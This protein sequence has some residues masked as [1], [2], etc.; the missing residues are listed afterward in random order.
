M[1]VE[2][3]EAEGL[4]IE[5][6]ELNVTL[7]E[8]GIG[9]VMMQPYVEPNLSNTGL[10]QWQDKE[11]SRQIDRITRTLNIADRADHACG[12]THFTIFPEYSIPGLEGIRRIEEKL[13]DGSWKNETIVLGG[14]D[15]LTKDDYSELCDG[16]TKD[17]HT[18]NNA[19]EVGDDEWIN[20]A[21]LWVKQQDGSLGRW[22]QP[23]MTPAL[24]ERNISYGN[25]FCGDSV[26]VFRCRFKNG[27]EC[28]FMVLICFDFMGRI[29]SN[30]GIRA[31]LSAV[32]KHWDDSS[33]KSIDLIFLLEHNEKP[34]N[35]NFL[36]NA[37][38]Y[39][40]ETNP[41]PSI[42]R[43]NSALFF[44]NTA[45]G[46][47]PGK[48]QTYGHSSLVF[49]PKVD[50][51]SVACPPSFSVR[52][53]K[54]RGTDCLGR[55][56][57][58]LFR[59][60]GACVHSF[61]FRSPSFIDPD[62]SDRCLPIDKANVHAIEADHEAIQSDQTESAN[63][64]SMQGVESSCTIEKA[65]IVEHADIDPRISGR[66]VPASVKWINDQLDA[67]VPLFQLEGEQPL[68]E[69]IAGAHEKVGERIRRQRGDLLCRYVEMT[70]PE[71]K[72][73]DKW[74]EIGQQKHH[75]VDN[76]GQEEA[77]NL[78]NVLHSLSVIEACK[79]LEVDGSP[80]HATIKLNNESD[81]FDIIVVTG[82]TNEDCI[83]YAIEKYEEY[84]GSAQRSVIVIIR[85]QYDFPINKKIFA[86]EKKI[87]NNGPSITSP[88]HRFIY[89]KYQD[90]IRSCFIE[91]ALF[92]MGLELQEDLENKNLSK[93]LQQQFTNNDIQLPQNATI[94]VK[95]EQDVWEIHDEGGSILYVIKKEDNRLNTYIESE[96]TTEL[97]R[98]DRKLNKVMKLE[99]VVRREHTA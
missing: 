18:G 63:E 43:D 21:V 68:R 88:E 11:K 27:T 24:P 29:K 78:E 50:F 47:K 53:R 64:M 59:E 38:D 86:L 46:P 60:S 30:K 12:K 85:D 33:R 1:D 23:K 66:P 77:Q 57:D 13:V 97:D 87:T 51:R 69:R 83:R 5:G 52:T 76:W 71:M 41:Y 55:C 81:I 28:H 8:H 37:R 6:I 14:V 72:K 93:Q 94:R 3:I 44:V 7:P 32:V 56:N 54:I 84:V 9:V 90:V 89:C 34:N 4:E 42:M 95:E 19:D 15:A 62:S 35:L 65:D 22:I 98:L 31:V 73:Q 91:S 36:G 99:E 79:S 40:Q 10:P 75:S 61:R 82:K 58:A 92:S 16:S 2:D 17:V 25:M 20:C 39:F 67:M 96:G 49:S 48:Y 70:S 80:T 45:G 26:Y 74:I